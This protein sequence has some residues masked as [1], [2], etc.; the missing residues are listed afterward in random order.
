MSEPTSNLP[1]VGAP[2]ADESWRTAV[3]LFRYT[4]ILPLLRHNRDT[5]GSKKDIRAAIAARP[6]TIPHAAAP[7]EV[8]TQVT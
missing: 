3:A 8:A 6:H 4:T 7:P 5:D 1:V 2:A